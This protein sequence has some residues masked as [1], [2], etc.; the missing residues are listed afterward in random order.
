M[1]RT[2]KKFLDKMK[3]QDDYEKLESEIRNSYK[4]KK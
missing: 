4:F 1:I 2:S 3:K